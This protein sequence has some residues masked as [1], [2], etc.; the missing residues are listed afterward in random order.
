M[1]RLLVTTSIEDSWDAN[2]STVFLGEWC[3][4]SNRQHIWSEIESEVLPPYGLKSKQKVSDIDE[5][6]ELYDILLIELSSKL[7]AFHQTNHSI[8]YWTIIIGPW[9]DSF[10]MVVMNR[11]KSLEV[12]LNSFQIS[13]TILVNQKDFSLTRKDYSD[14]RKAINSDLWNNALYVEILKNMDNQNVEILIKNIDIVKSNK[15]K[16]EFSLKSFFKKIFFKVFDFCSF[17][18]RNTDAFIINS[19]L[20]ILDEIKLKILLWQLPIIWKSPELDFNF[21]DDVEVDRDNI[22]LEFKEFD[23]LERELRRLIVKLI[24]KI[25]IEGY[26]YM[27]K[28]ANT[29]KWPTNPKF[30]YTSNNFTADELF[31]FWLAFQTEQGV[32]YYAGQHGANYGTFYG[33]KNWTELNTVDRFY[34]WG[35]KDSYKNLNAI[36]AF[37]FGIVNKKTLKHLKNGKLILAERSP[38]TRDGIHDRFYETSSSH[39]EMLK[40]YGLLTKEVQKNSL[41]RLHHRSTYELSWKTKFPSLKVDKGKT[42]IFKLIK[43]SRLVLFNYDSA[44]LLELL[45]LNIPVICFWDE[46]FGHLLPQSKKYYNLLKDV[47]ILFDITTE[48]ADHINLNWDNIDSWWYSL[49]VQDARIKFCQEYSK[50][51]TNPVSSLKNLLLR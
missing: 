44:G 36:P 3:K 32:P 20:P 14:F 17:L 37:N 21:L 22:N 9:L 10:M 38:G 35:W 49:E 28:Q 19:Y 39:D 34:S 4:K 41:I 30:I 24:P 29:L 5:K 7:N 1:D 26:E 8:R 46:T 12:A 6:H 23:G 48:V 27:C 51:S 50:V 43:K 16:V 33:S 2:L 18:S 47:N 15:H 31:K 11:Y 25:Y 40:L 13:K 42:D 45:A